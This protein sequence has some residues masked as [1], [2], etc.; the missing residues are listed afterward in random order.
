MVAGRGRGV[1]VKATRK[2]RPGGRPL[3]PHVSMSLHSQAV[4]RAKKGIYRRSRAWA[5]RPYREPHTTEY[6]GPA[7]HQLP[8]ICTTG[9]AKPKVT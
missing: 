1:R 4:A 3:S 2:E 9:G 8:V 7:V 5:R 6:I